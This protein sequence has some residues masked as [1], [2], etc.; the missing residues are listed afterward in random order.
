MV[1]MED[2]EESRPLKRVKQEETVEDTSAEQLEGGKHSPVSTLERKAEAPAEEFTS[3]MFKILVE[4]FPANWVTV[5]AIKKYLGKQGVQDFVKV[6]KDPKWTNAYVT[7]KVG[8]D[9]VMAV[10]IVACA[11]RIWSFIVG[12]IQAS[13]PEAAQWGDVQKGCFEGNTFAVYCKDHKLLHG[14]FGLSYSDPLF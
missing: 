6:K 14:S 3:E 8:K 1:L 11:E 7:F 4:G 9:Q 13:S 12:R 10:D 2:M 5:G